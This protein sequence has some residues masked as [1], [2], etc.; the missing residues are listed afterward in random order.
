MGW[1]YGFSGCFVAMVLLDGWMLL[2]ELAKKDTDVHMVR[3]VLIA[4][5]LDG[6]AGLAG[7][8][9][10]T[11]WFREVKDAH[12]RKGSGIRPIFLI[13]LTDQ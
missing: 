11:V 1:I 3:G 7:G 13:F 8:G 2:S 10:R 12:S 4:I 6:S 9:T 5:A